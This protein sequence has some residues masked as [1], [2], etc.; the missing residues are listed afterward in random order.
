MLKSR[1][2]HFVLLSRFSVQMWNYNLW[3]TASPLFILPR[4]FYVRW[5][6]L[7]HTLNKIRKKNIGTMRIWMFC[8]VLFLFCFVCV[9]LCFDEYKTCRSVSHLF[10][11][12]NSCWFNVDGSF[13]SDV[14]HQTNINTLKEPTCLFSRASTRVIG[15]GLFVRMWTSPF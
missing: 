5:F 6:W 7:W 9:V 13:M 14:S 2:S 15:C 1:M 11:F 10:L 4:M 3:L 12:F 8:F